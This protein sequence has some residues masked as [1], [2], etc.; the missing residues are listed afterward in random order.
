VMNVYVDMLIQSKSN[1]I[2]DGTL[3]GIMVGVFH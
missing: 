3:L 2:M 1:S